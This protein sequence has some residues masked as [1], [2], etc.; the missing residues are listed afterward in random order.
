MFNYNIPAHP[1]NAPPNYGHMQI[2][3][4]YYFISGW[5]YNKQLLLPNIYMYVYVLLVMVR[6]RSIPTILLP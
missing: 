3:L 6:E 4:S 1:T 2:D 5:E